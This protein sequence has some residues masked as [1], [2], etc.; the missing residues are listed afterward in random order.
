MSDHE[1]RGLTNAP[2]WL[3]WTMTFIN[4]VGFPIAVAIYLGYM[5]MTALPKMTDALKSMDGTMGRVEIAIRDN[6]D[7][8]K[9][10]RFRDRGSRSD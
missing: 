1:R 10:W 9:T 2:D 4:R 6:T 7:V 5:Q 8:L 3:I